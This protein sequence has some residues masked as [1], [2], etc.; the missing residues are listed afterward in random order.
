MNVKRKL[1]GSRSL[2]IDFCDKWKNFILILLE[3]YNIN[4]IS[5][6]KQVMMCSIRKINQGTMRKGAWKQGLFQSVW[7]KEASLKKW[8]TL[9]SRG[10]QGEIWVPARG[11]TNTEIWSKSKLEAFANWEEDWFM[12]QKSKQNNKKLLNVGCLYDAE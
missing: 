4:Y 1:G 7:S 5:L 9:K 6:L 11:L 12:K 10:S 8:V 3:N 2:L